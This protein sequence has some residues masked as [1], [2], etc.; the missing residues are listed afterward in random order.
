M[1][2]K[3]VKTK[4]HG[5]TVTKAKTMDGTTNI[6]TVGAIE[7]DRDLCSGSEADFDT[8]EE[9]VGIIPNPNLFHVYA[10]IE[11]NGYSDWVS[12]GYDCPDDDYDRDWDK[13]AQ[14]EISRHLQEQ[15]R[16]FSKDC[17]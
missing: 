7:F 1:K 10:E 17:S 14:K 11:F 3:L 4:V 16:R 6:I 15:E 13:T 8:D 2:Y 9:V 5:L 12:L